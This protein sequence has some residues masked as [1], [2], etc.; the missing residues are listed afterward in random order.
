MLS[1][2]EQV[3]NHMARQEKYDGID[4]DTNGGMTAIGKIIRDAW[5]F[6]LIPEN[7]TC[8]GWL[9]GTINALHQKVNAEWDKYGCLV[10][11]LPDELRQRHERIYQDAIEKARAAGWAGEH[12]LQDD[13]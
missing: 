3:E 10:S 1:D 5:L 6:E 13:K 2:P 12:E 8:A 9:M 4:N 11:Q 7:E